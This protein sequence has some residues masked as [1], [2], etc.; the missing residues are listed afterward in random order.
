MHARDVSGSHVIVRNPSKETIPSP[1][2]ERAAELAAYYSKRRSDTLC[3][4][5]HT[6]RKYIRKPKGLA[7]GAVKVDKERVIMV[8]PKK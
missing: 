4:V 8:V 5:I 3:P 7:P 6:P 1:V 2:L